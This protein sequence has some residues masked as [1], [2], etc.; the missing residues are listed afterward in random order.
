MEHTTH[1]NNEEQAIDL[2]VLLRRMLR[3]LRRLWPVCLALIVLCAAVMGWRA[4]RTFRPMYRS[5]AVFSVSLS[6]IGGTDVSSYSQY[7]NKSAAQQVT[8]TFPYLLSSD[9]MQELL[10]QRLEGIVEDEANGQHGD[11]S[12]QNTLW[13]QNLAQL[14]E[15]G[16]MDRATWDMLSRLYEL[17]ITAGSGSGTAAH[18]NLT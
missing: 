7:Y 15:T 10:R 11:A 2:S 13:L 8:D 4:H 17:F 18:Q 9:R 16:V 3:A 14:E 5:E 6:F 12:V 1:T